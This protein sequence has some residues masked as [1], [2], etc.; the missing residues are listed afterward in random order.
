MHKKVK[1]DWLHSFKQFQISAF[2]TISFR[3]PYFVLKMTTIDQ[4]LLVIICKFLLQIQTYRKKSTRSNVQQ[5]IFMLHVVYA[6]FISFPVRHT[7]NYWFDVRFCSCD[8]IAHTMVW[9]LFLQWMWQIRLYPHV[10]Q[11]FTR[12]DPISDIKRTKRASFCCGSLFGFWGFHS[13]FIFNG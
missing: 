12:K 8:L 7:D 9:K 13:I 10:N 4:G 2:S 3:Y 1:G 11:S 6:L 5:S